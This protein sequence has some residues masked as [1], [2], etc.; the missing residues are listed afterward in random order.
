MTTC[1]WWEDE[2][3]DAI[4][5][6]V[7]RSCAWL[8]FEGNPAHPWLSASDRCMAINHGTS[9]P[10]GSCDN[11]DMD[12][13]CCFNNTWTLPDNLSWLSEFDDWR[14]PQSGDCI[15]QGWGG[16]YAYQMNQTRCDFFGG[17]WVSKGTCDGGVAGGECPSGNSCG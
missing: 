3:E 13:C 4:K 15:K 8:G 6:D 7:G 10:D 5:E 1:C 16:Y 14:I 9:F 11:V 12:G 2:G 17:C